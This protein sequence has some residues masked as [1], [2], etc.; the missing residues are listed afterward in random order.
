MEK[1]S[2]LKNAPF[3][4]PCF[5][6]AMLE[7]CNRNKSCLEKPQRHIQMQFAHPGL[8]STVTGA[9]EE[10]P[11]GGARA[12]FQC[13]PACLAVLAGQGPGRDGFQSTALGQPW[14]L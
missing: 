14:G 12:T 13:C 8:G 6:L 1:L 10:F 5:C 4:L 2:S 7:K 9:A 11:G 3:L